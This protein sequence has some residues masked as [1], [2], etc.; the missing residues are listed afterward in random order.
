MRLR[1]MRNVRVNRRSIWCVRLSYCSPAPSRFTVTLADTRERAA[2]RRRDDGVGRDVVG[3]EPQVARAVG[4]RIEHQRLVGPADTEPPRQRVRTEQLHLR[5]PIPFLVT[6]R[7]QYHWR[8][9]ARGVRG[10]RH[11][12]RIVQLA[13]DIAGVGHGPAHVEAALDQAAGSADVR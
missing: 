3:D 4:N 2:Q 6:L 9:A 12:A 1:P 13:D 8:G 7:V 10:L 5:Q 11:Q